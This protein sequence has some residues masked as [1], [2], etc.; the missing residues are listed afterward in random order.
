MKTIATAT[1]LI[2][3]VA[4]FGLAG[5]A[6]AATAS[7]TAS[8]EIVSAIA[9]S[10]TTGLNFGQIAPERHRRHA[11]PSRPPACAAAWAG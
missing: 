11:F 10:S 5:R 1:A 8:A 3:L 7:G 2:G 9:I 6:S 4:S